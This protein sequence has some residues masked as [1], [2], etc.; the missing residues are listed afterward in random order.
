MRR[1]Y[2]DVIMSIAGEVYSLINQTE[3]KFKDLEEKN[4]GN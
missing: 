3:E 4:L 2:G 1:Y